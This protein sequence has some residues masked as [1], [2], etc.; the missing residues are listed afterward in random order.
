MELQT[1]TVKK[2]ESLIEKY[3]PIDKTKLMLFSRLAQRMT[4]DE[5]LDFADDL[6]SKRVDQANVDPE[7]KNAIMCPYCFH[8]FRKE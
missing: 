4:L 7:L 3:F 5:I 1:A 2:I 8:V 6:L